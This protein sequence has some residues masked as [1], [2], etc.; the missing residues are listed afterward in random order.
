MLCEM[1]AEGLMNRGVSCVVILGCTVAAISC[2]APKVD[3]AAEAEAVRA[4]NEACVAAEAAQ[5]L[6]ATL[7]FFAEDAV[8]QL[9][10]APQLQGKEAITG[11][12]RQ[13]FESGFLDEFS[14][15]TLQITVAQSGDLAYEYG[16]NRVILPGPE[17][18][19]LLLGKYL[20][21]WKKINAGWFIA[22]NSVTWDTPA[23]TPVGEQ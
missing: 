1:Q 21:V 19:L 17:G 6:D 2:G 5:D 23:P 14:A 15:E 18:D 22:A 12:Y 13:L 10:E 20:L 4:R 3:L 11:M 7:A 16:I 9:P 8:V